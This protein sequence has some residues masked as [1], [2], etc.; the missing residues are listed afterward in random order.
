[1]SVSGERKR[2]LITVRTYPV[3]SAKSVEASCTA[4]ITAEGE[5]IRL[6]PIPYR[7]LDDTQKFSKYDWIE[8]DLR[9]P[10]TDTRPESHTP[11][12]G[13]IEIVGSVPTTDGWRARKELL[14]PLIRPSMCSIQRVHREAGAPTLGLFKPAEIK[15][16][17]I[18][19][20]KN[21]EWTPAELNKLNPTLSIFERVTRHRPAPL[22]KIPFN[23]KYEFRCDD[24]ECRGHLM[25]CTDWEMGQAYRAWRKEYG[26]DWEG[27]FRQRFEEGMIREH[28]TYFYVGN[29]HQHPM[30]WQIVGLFYPPKQLMADLFD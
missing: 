2:I 11:D 29:L 26:D 22:E 9:K 16:L 10:R 12:L 3:P 14:K 7:S 18:E 6:F 30:T 24:P 21:Q 17:V 8:V 27:P 25:S 1:M 20:E 5:W 28:D 23:F 19:A 4:G 15:R 13:T